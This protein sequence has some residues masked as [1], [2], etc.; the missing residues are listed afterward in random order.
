[1]EISAWLRKTE[2][3]FEDRSNELRM[4]WSLKEIPTILLL[5]IPPS[6]LEAV[7]LPYLEEWLV[8]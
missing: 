2:A 7:N 6:P 1:M 8:H 5:D 3:V 4:D